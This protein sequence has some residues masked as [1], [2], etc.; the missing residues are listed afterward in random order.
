MSKTM[1]V[2]LLA[3]MLTSGAFAS[4]TVFLDHNTAACGPFQNGVSLS[5]TWWNVSGCY[6]TTGYFISGGSCVNTEQADGALLC[7]WLCCV[8]PVY[9]DNDS[10]T[11]NDQCDKSSLSTQV[12]ITRVP[13]R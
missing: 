3:T 1:I 6:Q 9:T 7:N 12:T 5:G 13:V 11:I 8:I 4:Q 10:R 2:F